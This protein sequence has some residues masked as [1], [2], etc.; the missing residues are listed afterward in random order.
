V[1]VAW[2]RV[3]WKPNSAPTARLLVGAVQSV[4]SLRVLE[5][6]DLLVR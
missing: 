6:D 3:P 1:T 4:S 5:S 2:S